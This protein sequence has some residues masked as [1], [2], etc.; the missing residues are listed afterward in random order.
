MTE[1]Q[2]YVWDVVLDCVKIGLTVFGALWIYWRYVRERTHARRVAFIIECNF[3]GPQDGRIVVEFLLRLKNQGLVI[4]KLEKLNLR[5]R[6]ISKT[7]PIR[8]WALY[9][10]RLEFPRKLVEDENVTLE[11]RY[12][13]IFVEPGVEQIVT[14]A[15][16]IPEDTA[17]ITARALF[18]YF[19]TDTTHSAERVF[20]V[21]ATTSSTPLKAS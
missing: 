10:P 5:V 18:Y 13:H 3:Y 19:G 15:A 20:E 9:P 8:E 14:Y 1:S 21:R 7:D 11:E 4:H 2:K 17:F 6:G 12:S 16:S